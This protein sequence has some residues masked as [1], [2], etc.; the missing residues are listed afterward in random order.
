MPTEQQVTATINQIKHQTS[1]I[2]P[3]YAAIKINGKKMY[4]YAR[5]GERVER[6][7]RP[8]TIHEI[9]LKKYEYPT[10]KISVTCSTGTYIRSIARDIGEILGTGAY[11]SQLTRTAIGKFE[12]K[13]SYTIESLPK[14]IHSRIIPMEQLVSHIPSITCSANDVAKYKQGKMG[15]CDETIPINTSIALLD[16]DKKLFG[17]AVRE[18]EGKILKPKKIFL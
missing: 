6:Q 7:P 8:V 9:I 1:Q 5:A 3:A 4:E 18:T 17:I 14:V 10:L 11:C 16:E 13:N 12:L 2:P 15:E